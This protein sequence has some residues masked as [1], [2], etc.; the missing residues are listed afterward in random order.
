M[1]ARNRENDNQIKDTFIFETLM[2]LIV[3]FSAYTD[4]AHA[5]VAD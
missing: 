3:N 2:M 4:V 1:Y 5:L